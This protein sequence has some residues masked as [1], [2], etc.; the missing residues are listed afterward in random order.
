MRKENIKALKLLAGFTATAFGG[1]GWLCVSTTNPNQPYV[2][3]V[4]MPIALF[5]IA[6]GSFMIP[7]WI[8]E[9]DYKCYCKPHCNK[10]QEDTLN[11]H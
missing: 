3:L 8:D 6:V 2:W 1:M 4:T 7:A 9:N 5:V 10:G 11:S